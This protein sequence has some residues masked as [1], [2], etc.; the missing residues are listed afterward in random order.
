MAVQT[1]DIRRRWPT[2]SGFD[3]DTGNRGKCRKHGLSQADIEAFFR[4]TIAVYRDPDHSRDEERLKA[5][6][7]TE[8]GRAVVVVFSLRDRN[9]QTLIRPISARYMHAKEV[10]NYEKEA[11]AFGQ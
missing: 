2:I 6:G 8:N 4:G 10:A 9:E 5:T 3:G 1:S 11:A 7:K